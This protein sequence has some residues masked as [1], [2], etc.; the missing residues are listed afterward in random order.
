[1]QATKFLGDYINTAQTQLYAETGAFFAF[2]QRQLEEQKKPNVKY[3][4]LGHGMICPEEQAQKLV[5]GITNII[6]QGIAQDLAE[7]GKTAI[8]TREL[9]NHEAFY[10]GDITDTVA[11][12]DGYGFT[13]ADIAAVYREVLPTVDFN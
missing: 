10:V 3:I 1:M 7:N 2:N 4:S 5:D 13:R 12:L 6:A 9:H 11:A 8:I